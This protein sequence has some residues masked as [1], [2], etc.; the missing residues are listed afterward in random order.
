MGLQKFLHGEDR[1]EQVAGWWGPDL[2]EGRA[3]KGGLD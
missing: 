2:E 1:E 3:P